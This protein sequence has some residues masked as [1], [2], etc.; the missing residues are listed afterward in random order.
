MPTLAMSRPA[1]AGPIIPPAVNEL[2][3]RAT[4]LGRSSSPTISATKVW[5]TGARVRRRIRRGRREIDVP[6]LDD[7]GEGERGED[8]ASTPMVAWVS[9][10]SLR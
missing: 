8:D 9:M 6:E 2:E 1:T 7:S 5:R 3:F 4:A 10:R